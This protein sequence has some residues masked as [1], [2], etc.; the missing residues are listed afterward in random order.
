MKTGAV[1]EVSN[2]IKLMTELQAIMEGHEVAAKDSSAKSKRK[3]TI[4]EKAGKQLRDAAMK[5]LA[6]REGLIDVSKVDGATVR[7]KQGQRK[8]PR[9]PVSPRSSASDDHDSDVEPPPKRRARNHILHDILQKR[10]EQDTRRLDDAR[11]RA[12]RQHNQLLDAQN[13]SLCVLRDLTNEIKGL[14]EDYRGARD[15][16]ERS[17]TTEILAEIVA[18]KF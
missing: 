6:R 10:T 17:R 11:E 1:E 5:G 13:A 16:G 12:D 7:E 18:K 9:R 14:R 2:H 3:A 15:G 8:R 4:E